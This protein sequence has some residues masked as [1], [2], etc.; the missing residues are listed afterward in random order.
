MENNKNNKREVSISA[1]GSQIVLDSIGVQQS[2]YSSTPSIHWKELLQSLLEFK[3]EVDNAGL[4]AED[5]IRAKVYLEDAIKESEKDNPNK[6]RI[7][8]KLREVT[9]AFREAGKTITEGTT[10]YENLSKI[11]K[12]LGIA[13]SSLL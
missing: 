8:D 13:I 6:S 10:I 3:K 12:T 7:I 1:T 2:M 5:Q 4:P 11:A 9:E